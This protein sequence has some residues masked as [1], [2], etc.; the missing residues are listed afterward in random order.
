[1]AFVLVTL[2][3]GL[4]YAQVTTATVSGVVTDPSGGV[5]PGATVTL[6]SE[7]TAVA[8][9]TVSNE[10][11]EFTIA[12]VPVGSYSVEVALS[13]FADYT[14]EGMSLSAAQSVNL[15][16]PLGMS[17]VTDTVTVSG[18]TPLVNRTNAQQQALVSDQQLRELPLG[19]RDWSNSVG[20]DTSVVKGGQGGIS[21]NGL[22]PGALSLTIDGTNGTSDTELSSVTVYQ[23]FNT[24]NGVSTRPFRRSASARASPPRSSA[25]RW[26]AT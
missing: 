24:I 11:G 16:I 3:R 19:S 1:M 22:P 17:G 2:C 7:T 13:G 6:T 5:L 14:R 26:P 8:F 25:A 9:S 12:F 10:R 18:A 15:T 21:M 4:A 20:L 23:G